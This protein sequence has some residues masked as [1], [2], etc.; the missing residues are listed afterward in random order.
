MSINTKV[1]EVQKNLDKST[2]ILSSNVVPN[3]NI[4]K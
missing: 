3:I 1:T 2:H 4:Y